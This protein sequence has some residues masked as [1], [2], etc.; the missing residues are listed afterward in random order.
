[1]SGF[2]FLSQQHP[3]YAFTIRFTN[4]NGGFGQYQLMSFNFENRLNGD[5]VRLMNAQKTLRRQN[6][7]QFG[8]SHARNNQLY[9]L[10]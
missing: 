3:L 7:K 10:E 5:D 1:M 4:G 6:A 2:C 9:G 8:D